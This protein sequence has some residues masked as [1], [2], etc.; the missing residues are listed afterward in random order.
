MSS[1]Q[2]G[3]LALK[4]RSSFVEK[5]SRFTSEYAL[6]WAIII[7]CII[8]AIASPSFLTFINVRNM[9][10]Q[11]SA[12]G[13]VA[14]GQAFIILTGE[15]DMS[16]GMNVMMTSCLCAWMIKFGGVN[17]W[18]A[19]LIALLAGC[20]VGA[21][22]GVLIAY[23]RI[24]CFVVTLGTQLICTG[25]GKIIT[26]DS[27]IPSMPPELYIFGRK[28]IGGAEFGLPSSV[29][30]LII[31]YIIF[32]FVARKTRLGRN[33]YAMGGNQEAA[34]FA[35]IDVKKFRMIAYSIAGILSA[36]GGVVLL[37]RLDSAAV[38]SGNGYEFDTI[39]SCVIGGVSLAGGKG[40]VVQAL[41]GAFFLTLFFNGMTMLNVHPFVQNV[42]KGVVLILAV[43]I[44]VIRN[45]R[46]N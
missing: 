41:I 23:A 26:N 6:V 39:I 2:N 19:I 42:L 43:S 35:G 16:L 20:A 7:L 32:S 28:F 31:L 11:T 30:F 4:G 22:N 38:T 15:F 17:P 21:L 1:N 18:I 29:A 37:S 8:F 13:I 46:R 9:L 40:K 3:D 44:D 34:Y 33:F 36:F 24:P 14:I 25:L 12:V 45:K 10:Q 5:V 27:P